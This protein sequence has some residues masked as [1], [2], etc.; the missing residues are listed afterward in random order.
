MHDCMDAGVRVKQDARTE[1]QL[2]IV[3]I[4]FMN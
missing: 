2:P 4:Y 1:E 3:I